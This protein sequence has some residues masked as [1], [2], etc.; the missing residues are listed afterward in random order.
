MNTTE[1]LVEINALKRRI[2]MLPE[3]SALLGEL[4]VALVALYDSYVYAIEPRKKAA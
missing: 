1:M 4:T 2:A 3:G